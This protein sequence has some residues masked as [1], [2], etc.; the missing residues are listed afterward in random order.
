[1]NTSS[2]PVVVIGAG[3]VGLAAAAHLLERGL[4]PAVFEAGARVGAGMRTWS[5][6][7]MFSPWEFTI[8]QAAARILARDGWTAPELSGFPSGGE[9][10]ER[11]L[12]PLARTPE[13]APH[14]HLGARVTA[15][16]KQRRDRMKDAQRD[17]VPFVVRYV[18]GEGEHELLAQAVI[19]ASGTIDTPNPLGASGLPALGER[20]AQAQ[21]FYGMPDVLGVHRDRY[22]GKRVL[23]VGSG[24]SA[25]N[26]LNDL[27]RLAQ[28]APGTSIQ[29]AIRRP[30]LNRV[31]GGGE[32]DQLAERGRL[33]LTVARL[34]KDGA[35]SVATSFQLDRIERTPEGWVAYSDG[36]ALAPVD[37]IVAATGFRP[38]VELLS[39]LRIALDAGTQAPVAL[40]PL[41]DPNQH[42]CGSVR[43]HGAEQLRHPDANVYIVGMKSYGRAPTFLLLTGY[44]QV[45]S[46][47][48]AIAGDWDAARRVELVLPET[49]VCIT[50]FAD[51]EGAIGTSTS[52]CGPTP[53]ETAASPVAPVAAVAQDA[54]AG[55]CGGPPKSDVEACCVKDEDAK[56]SGAA[57]CGCG[58]R[59]ANTVAVAAP[60]AAVVPT[61]ATPA[62]A[63]VPTAVAAS[64]CCR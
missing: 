57:G 33:G 23:V 60:A 42:S 17:D 27:A 29:W 20:G 22:A 9:V 54:K 38:D 15:V 18:D 62:S 48:A 21:V 4:T 49:G 64:Q 44:E 61:V 31:L 58:T 63:I 16:S 45:R 30:S 34:V 25:F 13:I 12:E 1:M 36:K 43:P 41:I 7:R 19:D 51:E 50:Q 37:Q 2:L 35:L 55:C 53:A 24:H 11:Y 47:V 8:D 14:L 39:E 10:A 26:V 5:H 32:N 46:V 52:C 28:Q 6:V 59:A 56:A 40:A 3:P